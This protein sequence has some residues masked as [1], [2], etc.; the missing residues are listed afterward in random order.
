MPVMSG[1]EAVRALRRDGHRMPIIM[2]STLS[3][4]GAV[5]TLDALAAGATDYVTKPANVGSVQESLA[6]VADELIPRIKGLA[7]RPGGAAR[8]AGGHGARDAVPAAGP[9]AARRG[10]AHA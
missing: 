7:R 1:I 10:A 5:A 6:R 9:P 4:R 3:E 8:A 2:F